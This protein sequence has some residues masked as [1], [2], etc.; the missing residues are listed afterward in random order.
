MLYTSGSSGQPKG[1][2]LHHEHVLGNAARR[3][4]TADDRIWLGSP[5]FY[6]L[7]ATNVLPM[8]MTAGATLVIQDRFTPEGALAAIEEHGCTTYCG[9]SNRTRRI[10][11]A[12]GCTAWA[13]SSRRPA[14][15]AGG[16]GPAGSRCG[17]RRGPRRFTA[18][19]QCGPDPGCAFAL[20]STRRIDRT[21]CL[22]R[23]T[24][25][26]CATVPAPVHV[27]VDRAGSM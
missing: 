12:A 7:G 8:A 14:R 27:S 11:E 25:P 5:L 22:F 15:S 24:A 9:T 4:I 10:V 26:H 6:G 17:D 20:V 1:V 2:V 21:H 3:R 16:P 18:V 23:A 19:A 13:T